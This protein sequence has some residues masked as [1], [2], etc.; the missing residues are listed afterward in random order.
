MDATSLN[1]A[2]IVHLNSGNAGV[3]ASLFRRALTIMPDGEM[4]AAAYFNL[5][6]ALK[7][8]GRHRDS[9]T[10]Y[11]SALHLHP[12][13]PQAHFN[14]GRCFQMLA[15]DAGASGYLNSP[16]ARRQILLRAAHHFRRSANSARAI[17]SYRSLEE[18][19]HQLGDEAAARSAYTELLRRAPHNGLPERRRVPCSRMRELLALHDAER[20]AADGAAPLPPASLCRPM[21]SAEAIRRAR[22]SFQARGYAELPPLLDRH[23]L[24]YAVH[25]YE[26]LARSSRGG[27]YRDEP[28]PHDREHDSI[29]AKDRWALDNDPLGLFLAERIATV[30]SRVTGVAARPGFV[31]AAWYT[32][33][34][35]LPPHRDQVQNLWSISLTLV[36]PSPGAGAAWPLRLIS[37]PAHNPLARTHTANLTASV[38]F[39]AG[40]DFLHWRPCCLR[41]GEH[42]L[43]LLLHFVRADFPAFRC[44]IHLAAPSANPDGLVHDC[45]AQP[46][47]RRLGAIDTDADVADADASVLDGSDTP[48]AFPPFT[49]CDAKADAWLGSL[50]DVDVREVGVRGGATDA[51]GRGASAQRYLLYS[52]CVVGLEGPSY[53]LGQFNNQLHML[54]HAMAVAR[55]MQRT[56]VLPPFLWMANQSANEQHWFRASHFLDVCALRRRQPVVELE[57]FVE[58][59][60]LQTGGVL[61]RYAHPPYLLGGAGATAFNGEFFKTR[62]LRFRA[63]RV[64]SPFDEMQQS[65]SGR[66]IQGYAPFEGTGFWAAAAL[67]LDRQQAELAELAEH[68][69]PTTFHTGDADVRLVDLLTHHATE[70]QQWSPLAAEH[71]QLRGHPPPSEMNRAASPTHEAPDALVLDFAPAYNFNL[72]CFAFDAELEAIQRAVVFRPA[73]HALA[74]A[75]REEM[76]PGSERYLAI[77]LRRDGYEHYCA[78][79]GLARY[80]RRRFGVAITPSM[81][82]PSITQAIEAIHTALRRHSLS[83]VLLATNSIDAVELATLHAAAAVVRWQPPPTMPPEWVPHIELILC[84]MADAFV[85][86]LP[87]TYT[88]TV[89]A[90]RDARGWGR[91][92]SAF[93]GAL[94]FWHSRPG[95]W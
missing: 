52:P 54:W 85:G 14:L 50:H 27:F 10:A 17:D 55:A 89:L 84:A 25:H 87:S 40:R 83:R 3:A 48:D 16:A 45:A 26:A 64:A 65:T 75:A 56:L 63:P 23:A 78:G 5:G 59:V 46:R 93:F 32:A 90:Q 6:I 68:D 30:V 33:G 51:L 77:H 82:F 66:G 49:R 31:K 20:T 67:H 62:G 57:D 37:A 81:C 19:L 88:A 9:A 42:A 44:S 76:L 95:R 73:L 8:L 24:A 2:A 34:S 74:L 35:K 61:S 18:V 69:P 79:G 80:G 70:L 94:D 13:F 92:T 12:S 41:G 1:D 21:V 22:A 60:R 72:D 86:T 28:S 91:N 11:L 15:D 7:D 39:F 36:P 58:A 38:V 47:P 71:P 29:L 4:A 53:C 43:V